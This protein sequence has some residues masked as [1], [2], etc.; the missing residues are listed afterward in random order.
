MVAW[1]TQDAWALTVPPSPQ[2]GRTPLHFALALGHDEV[3]KVLR[4]A[5]AIG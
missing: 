3:A 1:G 4:E 5:G 2:G